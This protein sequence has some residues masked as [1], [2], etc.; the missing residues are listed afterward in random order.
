[1]VE[2]F[3]V[4]WLNSLL[5]RGSLQWCS[6]VVIPCAF[7]NGMPPSNTASLARG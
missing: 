7:S 4:V 5:N 2:W 6:N 1:M 3:L